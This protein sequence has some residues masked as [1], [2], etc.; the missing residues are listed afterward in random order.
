METITTILKFIETNGII[1]LFILLACVLIILGFKFAY[2]SMP[3]LVKEIMLKNEAKKIKE[4]QKADKL[5]REKLSR[6]LLN[7][8]ADRALIMEFHNGK[9]NLTGLPFRYG[10]FMYEVKSDDDAPTIGQKYDELNLSRYTAPAYL[11]ENKYYLGTVDD[12][13]KNIDRTLG[14][15][16][17]EDD[18]K[19]IC[20]LLLRQR[21]INIG[22][23]MLSYNDI[24]ENETKII[25]SVSQYVQEISSLLTLD[26]KLK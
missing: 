11:L 3:Y 17:E 13:K 9:E 26:E 5:I 6:L 18:A 24:Q 15:K 20:L 8:K 12:F 1:G 7:T 14:N 19:Y 4:R 16:L 25:G 10:T 2:E 21:D 22:I 23:L